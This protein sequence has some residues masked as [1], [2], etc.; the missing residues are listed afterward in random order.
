LNSSRDYH[1]AQVPQVPRCQI[2]FS[3]CSISTS[4][5]ASF[6][7]TSKSKSYVS[8]GMPQESQ[9]IYE[10]WRQSRGVALGAE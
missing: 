9:K 2:G 4:L 10:R 1:R 8:L 7:Y 5:D 3:S 6:L